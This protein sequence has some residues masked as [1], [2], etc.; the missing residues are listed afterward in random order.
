MTEINRRKFLQR[1]FQIGGIAALTGL[2]MGAVEDAIGFKILPA[3]A[4]GGGAVS[5]VSGNDAQTVLL[6]HSNSTDGSTTFVDSSQG[7][8][9]HTAGISVV[10]DTHHE[11]DQQKFGT[12]SIYFDGVGDY[13]TIPDHADWDFGAGDFCVEFWV[14]F[15]GSI[16]ADSGL[17]GRYNGSPGGWGLQFSSNQ[18]GWYYDAGSWYNYAWVPAINTWYHIAALRASGTLYIFVD[19]ASIGSTADGTNYDTNSA[20]RIGDYSAAG[21]SPMTGY[22]DEIAIHKGKAVYAAGG[23]TPNANAYCD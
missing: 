20:L 7:G 5:C 13:L 12:T 21:A 14:N 18:L 11:T 19:G 15:G 22:L 9:D 4:G 3:I 2:G 6:I 10:G 8:T 23:F 1:C 16:D 17:I